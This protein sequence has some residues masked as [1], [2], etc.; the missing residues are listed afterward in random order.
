MGMEGAETGPEAKPSKHEAIY[1]AHNK[2]ERA[3]ERL[4]KL[5]NRIRQINPP[6]PENKGQKQKAA[7]ISFSEFLNSAK[8][9][10][11][12]L[13]DRIGKACDDIRQSTF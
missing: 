2:L 13:T 6:T 9:E 12:E 8:G 5:A 3:I 1:Q 10:V 11:D 4:E 7:K